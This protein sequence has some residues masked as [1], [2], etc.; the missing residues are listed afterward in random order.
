[1]VDQASAPGTRSLTHDERRKLRTLVQG[2]GE[3][4]IVALATKAANEV[5]ARST[6]ERQNLRAE[7]DGIRAGS[8]S[9]GDMDPDFEFWVQ[10]VALAATIALGPE[11][12]GV[13]ELIGGLISWLVG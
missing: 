11:A 13:V 4:D 8:R 1:M 3:G 7:Y 10:A 5:G 12:G 2:H 9:D 6:A